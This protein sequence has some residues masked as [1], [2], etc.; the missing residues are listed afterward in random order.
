MPN[1]FRLD[2]V[3]GQKGVRIG[4][5]L[6]LEEVVFGPLGKHGKKTLPLFAGVTLHNLDHV[7]TTAR[8]GGSSSACW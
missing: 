6:E 4:H 7:R 2:V 5:G 8:H 1:D 3:L